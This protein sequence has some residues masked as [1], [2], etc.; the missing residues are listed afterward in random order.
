MF[1]LIFCSAFGIIVFLLFDCVL[2]SYTF[3]AVVIF[4]L[5][6]EYSL[7][8]KKSILNIMCMFL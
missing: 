4:T 2:Y 8:N 1:E 3:F 6:F 5:N 7:W